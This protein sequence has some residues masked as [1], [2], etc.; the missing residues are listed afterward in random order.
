MSQ[1]P[2][3]SVVGFVGL[4]RMGSVMA[5]HILAAGFPVIGWDRNEAAV[6]AFQR[7]GG[8]GA[9]VL[10]EV[11]AA[12]IVI[13]IVFDDEGTSEIALGTGGLVKTMA[14]ASTHIVMASISPALSRTIADAHAAHGQKYLAASVFGRPEAAAAAD[15]LINCSGQKA[16][17]E[18]VA[19]V[20]A[21]L[22]RTLWVGGEPEQAM[23]VKTFGNS[24]IYVVIELLREMF[25]FLKA[26][27]IAE[28]DAKR[29]LIDTLFPGQ[30]FSGYAQRYI[31]DP[32][33]TRMADNAQKDRRNCL[34]AAA[35]L[36]VDIPL[37]QFLRD[38]NLPG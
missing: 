33:S 34:Q 36:G 21:P 24:M 17:F 30:I 12:S 9:R 4:G 11:A 26:G 20:L 15:L 32:E 37:I 8:K 35:Q 25:P 27:G 10:A 14:P 3:G 13:S 23:L 16:V 31:D 22:G 6:A 1:T 7:N 38:R 29:L 5:Q 19:P 18:A 2:G 28:T